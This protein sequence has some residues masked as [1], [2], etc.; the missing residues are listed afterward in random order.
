[1]AARTT[2][3]AVG[4]RVVHGRTVRDLTPAAKCNMTSCT[5][6]FYSGPATALGT[7]TSCSH[8]RAAH[9]HGFVVEGHSQISPDLQKALVYVRFV[10]LVDDD[11]SPVA[12]GT[13]LRISAAG[14]GVRTAMTVVKPRS[15]MGWTENF[16]YYR[17]TEIQLTVQLYGE[18]RR[19]ARPPSWTAAVT[20]GEIA[21]AQAESVAQFEKAGGEYVSNEDVAVL[22]RSQWSK[23][24]QR[25]NSPLFHSPAVA[26]DAG[27]QRPGRAQASPLWTYSMPT[28]VVRDLPLVGKDGQLSGKR[29]RVV[30]WMLT[31]RTAYDFVRPS[32][33]TAIHTAAFLGDAT[34]LNEVEKQFRFPVTAQCADGM[35][36][37]DVAVA[38]GKLSIAKAM[39]SVS[40][41]SGASAAGWGPSLL[42]TATLDKGELEYSMLKR[43]LRLM[44]RWLVRADAR[45]CVPF[46]YACKFGRPWAA[47]ATHFTL[48]K[49]ELE[50]ALATWNNLPEPETVNTGVSI[51]Q[52][53]VDN[54]ARKDSLRAKDPRLLSEPAP[55]PPG[56]ALLGELL[57]WA[58][59]A[60]EYLQS[61]VKDRTTTEARLSV[62]DTL[63]LGGRGEPAGTSDAGADLFSAQDPVSRL[64]RQHSNN[65]LRCRD[66]EG[67][68]PLHLALYQSSLTAVGVAL[69]TFRHSPEADEHKL[70]EFA[71]TRASRHLAESAAVVQYLLNCEAPLEVVNDEDDTL[72]VALL[73]GI[74]DAQ[75]PTWTS[76]GVAADPVAFSSKRGTT[77][78]SAGFELQDALLEEIMDDKDCVVANGLC[79]SAALDLEGSTREDLVSGVV[80]ELQGQLLHLVLSAGAPATAV[81]SGPLPIQFAAEHC[82]A[83][84]VAVILKHSTFEPRE[85]SAACTA[86]RSAPVFGSPLRA[87]HRGKI[88]AMLCEASKRSSAIHGGSERL[89]YELS[90]SGLSS[91][92][93]DSERSVSDAASH[94]ADSLEED[95]G[96]GDPVADDSDY[97]YD[98]VTVG[99]SGD[100]A[101]DDGTS[102][103]HDCRPHLRGGA[104]ES[105]RESTPERESK[106]ETREDTLQGKRCGGRQ[107]SLRS[108]RSL[109]SKRCEGRQSATGGAGGDVA[110]KTHASPALS[111]KD[112][113]ML[114]ETLLDEV[115]RIT[116]LNK[117]SAARLVEENGWDV[118]RAAS[119][120]F[121]AHGDS[122]IARDASCDRVLVESKDGTAD[123]ESL[124]ECPTCFDDHKMSGTAMLSPCGHRFC[125]DCWDDHLRQQLKSLGRGVILEARCMEAG[126]RCPIDEES[127]S[128]CAKPETYNAFT[129]QL[130][131]S[132]EKNSGHG[133][134]CYKCGLF[135]EAA[136]AASSS[137]LVA[138]CTCGFVMCTCCGGADHRPASCTEVVVWS[139]ALDAYNNTASMAFMRDRY[140]QCP[141]CGEF[142]ER[143]QGCNH[144]TCRPPAGCGYEYCFL[145]SVDWKES[146]G[147]SHK[148]TAGVHAPSPAEWNQDKKVD[149]NKMI[150]ETVKG[151]SPSRRF[152]VC[153]EG[154]NFHKKLAEK[155]RLRS[156][157][158][159]KRTSIARTMHSRQ[160][161]PSLAVVASMSRRRAKQ[162]AVLKEAL[163]VVATMNDRL[164][165]S[166]VMLHGH[167]T[168][169][170][171]AS[172]RL[173]CNAQVML[174]AAVMRLVAR[175][176][177]VME[178]SLLLDTDAIQRDSE[179]VS[180]LGDAFLAIAAEVEL[181]TGPES[182]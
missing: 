57:D 181:S 155:A 21:E 109:R 142:T 48:L 159:D 72:V 99:G 148:C 49:I 80:Q 146:G 134:A 180:K 133:R 95:D 90:D 137:E 145:C 156:L 1:M 157:R 69:A 76:D 16:I 138:T 100:E 107:C 18:L 162:A 12:T 47:H 96:A 55:V 6:T 123:D 41:P 151:V 11:G 106:D 124:F 110:S 153:T 45:G 111:K 84:C 39:A 161:R 74:A 34:L 177:D 165:F 136:G 172:L 56:R 77:A 182:P 79:A 147:Y 166:Y 91:L 51:A 112:V 129:T 131:R 36:A 78:L 33:A 132:F 9:E 82:L 141:K 115:A 119:A 93:K 86:A 113:Q 3:G 158:M 54:A 179:S 27:G 149:V 178:E 66:S 25:L 173:F 50:K 170:E 101:D 94:G 28:W 75:E 44:N 122:P 143:S 42:H 14:P 43:Q 60:A 175:T 17:H 53:I 10:G 65:L 103:A 140:K 102:D 87:T 105:K 67:N 37:K 104:E 38:A 8:G 174:Q 64:V 73:R 154:Y 4:G 160:P 61:F 168:D 59:K 5:C 20:L 24:R 144:M 164:A 108:L 23:E 150:D 98:D 35:T 167:D 15:G 117:S 30:L 22:R 2:A 163:R 7:C 139:K 13:R 97:E 32:R 125:R 83:T 126:C 31:T 169:V 81:G 19:L 128:R 88:I 171:T 152:A 89:I 71:I 63:R 114:R 26:G 46:A 120:Y 29:L 92:T 118:H 58:C 130:I 85:L 127:W 176:S 135:L 62:Q 70:R 121:E 40:I 68:T 116:G 52:Q